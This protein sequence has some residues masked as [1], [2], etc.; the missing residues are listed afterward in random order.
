[1]NLKERSRNAGEHNFGDA[2]IESSN[3]EL[4]HGIEF[5][6]FQPCIIEFLHIFEWEFIHGLNKAQ[7]RN[8][9]VEDG[10]SDCSW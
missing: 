4:N 9:K 8:D 5:C 2:F 10:A 1:M 6:F 7:F 3:F